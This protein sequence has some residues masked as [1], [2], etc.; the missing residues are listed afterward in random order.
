M[1]DIVEIIEPNGRCKSNGC[2]R[3]AEFTV[4]WPGKTTEMC[5]HHAKHASGIAEAMGFT[6]PVSKIKPPQI[7]ATQ[8]GSEADNAP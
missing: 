4:F 7:V 3:K 1:S 5:Q 6:L 2:S 8:H